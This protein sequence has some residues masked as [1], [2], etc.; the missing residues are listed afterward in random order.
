MERPLGDILA[1]DREDAKRLRPKL[2]LQSTGP[3]TCSMPRCIAVTR[4]ISDGAE[5]IFVNTRAGAIVAHLICMGINPNGNL[6]DP[7]YHRHISAATLSR[8]KG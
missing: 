8:L 4:A 1:E 2:Q 6:S 3:I 7:A 5:F